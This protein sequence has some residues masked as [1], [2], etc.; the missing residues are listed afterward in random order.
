MFVVLWA[1]EILHR[2]ETMRHHF[3][4]GIYKGIYH[5]SQVNERRERWHV[6]ESGGRW[7]RDGIHSLSGHSFLIL[8]FLVCNVRKDKG[9]R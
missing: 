5:F 7:V 8:P 2:F 3:V 9:K 4:F 1:D 6:G